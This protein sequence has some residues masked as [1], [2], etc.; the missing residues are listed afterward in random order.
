MGTDSKI[1]QKIF[2]FLG[3]IIDS[4]IPKIDKLLG[5]PMFIQTYQTA[6]T[7][8]IK[9]SAQFLIDF[10]YREILENISIP[11]LIIQGTRDK[12]IKVKASRFYKIN[13]QNVNVIW[14]E[15]FAHS[16]FIT[17]AERIVPFIKEF[18]S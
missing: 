3:S 12:R 17:E 8:A 5:Y 13:N 10:D 16:G 2:N 7:N 6:N 9:E 4:D 11:T 14:L 18:T 15:N 1:L